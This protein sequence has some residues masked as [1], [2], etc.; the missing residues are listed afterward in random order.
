M[1]AHDSDTFSVSGVHYTKS[2][3]KFTQKLPLVRNR[4]TQVKVKVI[5]DETGLKIISES[6][7]VVK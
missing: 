5:F 3:G 4:S 7:R 2:D 6:K 1:V